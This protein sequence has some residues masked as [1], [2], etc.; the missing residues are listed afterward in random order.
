V[1]LRKKTG[2]LV[3]ATLFSLIGAL[4]VLS[5]VVLLGRF[6]S[7]QEQDARESGQRA[8]DAL[9]AETARLASL[10]Q[11]YATWDETYGFLAKPD[12]RF[13]R[14]GL[15][16]AAEEAVVSVQI[17]ALFDASGGLVFS[18]AIDPA[19]GKDEP[20]T[21]DAQRILTDPRLLTGPAKTGVQGLLLVEDAVALVATRPVLR[22]D[23]TGPSRGTLLMGRFVDAHEVGELSRY[24]RAGLAVYRF[25]AA[26]LPEDVRRAREA[27]QRAPGPIVTRPAP[28][29]GTASFAELPDVHGA[30]AL[31]V[32]ALPP[33]SLLKQGKETVLYLFG[34]LVAVCLVF[35]AVVFYAIERAVLSRVSRL[36]ASVEGI[37][38]S[39]DPAARV[40]LPGED[41]LSR[42]ADDVNEMLDALQASRLRLAESQGKLRDVVENSTNL[43]YSYDASQRI[44]YLSPQTRLFLDC[45]PEEAPQNWRDLLSEDPANAEGLEASRSALDTGV[46]QGVYELQL[47]TRKGRRVWVEANEAPVVRDGK[48]VE[49]VGALTDVTA[50]RIAELERSRLEDQLRQSQRIEAVG[51]LAGGVAH[52]FNNL[53]GVIL[54]YCELLDKD[55]D[56]GHKSRKRLAHIREAAEKAAGLTARL[57]AFSRKQVLAPE[58]LDLNELVSGIEGML[59]RVIGEHIELLTRLDP[60][61]P[62]V[63]V[64]RGQFEQ[65]IV[66]MAVNA[67]DAMPKGGRLLI[68]TGFVELDA[69]YVTLH[70]GSRSGPQV[71]LAVSDNGEGMTPDVR[72]HIFE[73][74]FTTKE[75]GKGTGLGLAMVYGVVKQSEG[76]IAVYSEVGRGTTFRIYLQAVGE[77]APCRALSQPSPAALLGSETLLLVED[78]AP[79][80]LMLRELLEGAGY[81]V[82]ECGAPEDALP[83]ARA[84]GSRVALVLTDVI[85]PRLTG[86]EIATTITEALPGVKVL[87]M[88]GYTDDAIAHFGVLDPGTEFLS[89]PFTGPALLSRIREILDRPAAS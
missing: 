3:G 16:P 53:L 85:M 27:L 58:V 37:A 83:M 66:N 15:V 11:D 64:D 47:L 59:Q 68:E 63:K 1:T 49:V 38:K 19:T 51:R 67:R 13:A 12:A 28:D 6:A 25:D 33:R 75:V 80:R 77:D 61:I 21:P 55:L 78:E 14:T 87:F 54:G 40:S 56:P 32:R 45:A 36:S 41:E 42:L 81:T 31:I 86:P 50:R 69:L 84:R 39:V 60:G 20:L 9:A 4:F 2:L 30:P 52:D 35:V 7:L 5:R 43:F 88:S 29:D 89:K 73:P 71:V 18:R 48:T 57:L 62:R 44:T 10:T 65:V 24:A 74:F 72:S 79:L 76:F 23:S 26:Q 17:E 46:R 82:L 22:T 70:P 34:A 8:I